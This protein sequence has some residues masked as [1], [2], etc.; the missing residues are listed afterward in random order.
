M[1]K[2][3]RMN[4]TQREKCYHFLNGKVKEVQLDSG[5]LAESCEIDPEATMETLLRV[6]GRSYKM[7]RDDVK[8]GVEKKRKFSKEVVTKETHTIRTRAGYP[9]QEK[10]IDKELDSIR[11]KVVQDIVKGERKGVDDIIG[12]FDE[13]EDLRESFE[14]LI[15]NMEV[16]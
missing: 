6:S 2:V 9:M 11:D 8:H 15:V 12:M 7:G 10:R 4:Q 16:E 13:G 5:G 3:R 14:E 1:P